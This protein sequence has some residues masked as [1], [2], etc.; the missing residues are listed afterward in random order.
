MHGNMV[1]HNGRFA[2]H[3]AEHQANALW[4]DALLNGRAA[5]PFLQ[6]HIPK[7]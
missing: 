3:L 5:L 2:D 4:P 6:G 7:S 1:V